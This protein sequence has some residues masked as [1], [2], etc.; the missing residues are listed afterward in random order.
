MFLA[1]VDEGRKLVRNRY[2]IQ[3]QNSKGKCVFFYRSITF[4]IVVIS[5][6]IILLL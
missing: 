6:C 5:A 4:S 2:S 3:N 1:G